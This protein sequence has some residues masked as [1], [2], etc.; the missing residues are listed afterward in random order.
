MC[1]KSVTFLWYEISDN[2]HFIVTENSPCLQETLYE[3]H[4]HNK[5]RELLMNSQQFLYT[6][7]LRDHP[8]S[9]QHT[10]GLSGEK[11]QQSSHDLCYQGT[12]LCMPLYQHGILLPMRI[13]TNMAYNTTSNYLRDKCFRY[14]LVYFKCPFTILVKPTNIFSPVIRILQ[15]YMTF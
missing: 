8:G 5:E 14:S 9:K 11:I 3:C 7:E 1:V 2:L 4:D 10:A 6:M 15:Q 13:N 12:P